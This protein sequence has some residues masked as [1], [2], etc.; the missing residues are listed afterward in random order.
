ML[1]LFRVQ[2]SIRNGSGM[3]GEH[4]ASCPFNLY[5]FTYRRVCLPP[6]SH[7]PYATAQARLATWLLGTLKAPTTN[8]DSDLFAHLR[9][10][11]LHAAPPIIESSIEFR[12]FTFFYTQ[13]RLHCARNLRVTDKPSLRPRNVNATPKAASRQSGGNARTLSR[14]IVDGARF[15]R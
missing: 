11:T 13:S 12:A 7:F 1:P 2:R 3:N 8:E 6:S 10:N 4:H 15:D 9:L 5:S 14:A